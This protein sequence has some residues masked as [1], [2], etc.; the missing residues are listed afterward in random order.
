VKTGGILSCAAVQTRVAQSRVVFWYNE[1]YALV[2]HDASCVSLFLYLSP[3]PLT[4]IQF[5]GSYQPTCSISPPNLT[6]LDPPTCSSDIPLKCCSSCRAWNLTPSNVSSKALFRNVHAAHLRE[7]SSCVYIFRQTRDG[8][9]GGVAAHTQTAMKKKR[10]M[11]DGK[12]K[13]WCVMYSV[14]STSIINTV[15]KF[16]CRRQ[17]GHRP[18]CWRLLSLERPLQQFES[19]AVLARRLS[20]DGLL[21]G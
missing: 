6:H 14:H 10:Y 16:R 18:I 7:T 1:G 4:P 8:E 19:R 12:H 17:F 21:H 20:T 5:L 11:S 2:V 13:P 9:T 15:P 3:Q